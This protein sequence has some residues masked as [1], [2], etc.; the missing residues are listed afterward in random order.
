MS[1]PVM[2]RVNWQCLYLL[3]YHFWKWQC[4]MTTRV[5]HSPQ[6]YDPST[7]PRRLVLRPS[8]LRY[9]T[10]PVSPNK[11][12]EFFYLHCPL[13]ARGWF[14]TKNVEGC[15]R[16]G[17]NHSYRGFVMYVLSILERRLN[18]DGSLP[19]SSCHNQRGFPPVCEGM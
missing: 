13:R 12:P 14:G 11:L 10:T 4:K 15:I 7:P 5:N 9:A 2:N 3:W 16:R 17:Q 18:R 19:Q 8:L 1:C 6:L